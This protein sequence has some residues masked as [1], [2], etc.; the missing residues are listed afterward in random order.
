[1]RHVIENASDKHGGFFDNTGA[2]IPW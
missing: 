2:T 1:M